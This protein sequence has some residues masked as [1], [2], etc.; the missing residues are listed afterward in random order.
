MYVSENNI[1]FLCIY[2][3]FIAVELRQSTALPVRN[4]SCILYLYCTCINTGGLRLYLLGNIY[5][6]CIYV[7]H[8]HH[9][10]LHLLYFFFILTVP[11]NSTTCMQRVM[12]L[13]TTCI[14]TGGLRL[15]V[16]EN[17]IYYLCI[18]VL[19]LIAI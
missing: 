14:N 1:Y 15:C 19:L 10:H 3:L 9:N 18:Y 13:Y 2:I 7:L 16:L 11:F 5:F 8:H 17:N 12:Y 4:T 6:L